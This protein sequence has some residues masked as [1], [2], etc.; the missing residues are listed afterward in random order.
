MLIFACVKAGE[1]YSADHV[2]ILRDM[3][4]RNCTIP[5]RF[6][7]FTDDARGLHEAVEPIALPPGVGGWWAKLFMFAEGHFPE[8]DRIVYFDLDTV[9]TG[10]LDEVAAYD[11]EFAIVRDFFRPNGLQSCV[12][13][14]PAGAETH[15]WTRWLEAGKP[16]PLG[17]DQEWIENV[18]TSPVILQKRF[19]G[20][21]VSYKLHC[22]GRKSFPRGAVAVQFHGHPKPWD[23]PDEWVSRLYKVGGGMAGDIATECNTSDEKLAHNIRT[24]AGRDLPWLAMAEPHDGHAVIVGGGPSAIDKVDEIQWRAEL[25]QTVFALNGAAGWLGDC[26]VRV[27]HQVILDARPENAALVDL[28]ARGYILASQC[29]PRVYDASKGRETT[30]FHA[31][32][33]DIDDLLP[34]TTK[35]VV[36]VAAGTTVGLATMAIAYAMGYRKLHLYGFDSSY[37][38]SL[39]HAY[40]Q[41]LNDADQVIEATVA[42]TTYKTTGWMVAQVNQFQRIAAEL[43]NGGAEITVHGDGLLPH[44]AREM[45]RVDVEDTQ[46]LVGGFWWPVRD[47]GAIQS[48]LDSVADLDEILPLVPGRRT[49]IQAGGNVGVWAAKLAESG[50]RRV[51]TFEPDPANYACMERNLTADNV[52]MYFAALGNEI[53]T[54]SMVRDEDN[55][56]ASFVKAGSDV[57]VMR[58]DDLILDACDLICLDI[59]GY[60]L[61]A[62]QG[63]KRTIGKF[64]PVIVAEDKGLSERYAVPMG[65]VAKYLEDNFG[66][67]IAKRIGRD[68]VLVP[69]TVAA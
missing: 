3:V 6:V 43:S 54:V 18:I 38:A 12:M 19:P 36:L 23:A 15:I 67:R 42:G 29:D 63:A 26:E 14:W 7:C 57:P 37:R 10:S 17:G 9:I 35:P 28:S 8:G 41:S 11:G 27:D 65:A 25:G 4:T 20:A 59:E 51:H 61:H 60:E 46:K 30:V 48:V 55:C 22:E 32:T 21:F 16:K 13:M 50:F 40:P 69:E 1:A 31:W 44:V 66:Y 5:H 53:G 64:R 68:L 49:V 58:I 34:P 47:Q 45:M 52:R 24:N 62:L 33:E 56:G 39:G 2:N